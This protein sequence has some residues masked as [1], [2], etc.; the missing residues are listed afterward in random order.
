MRAGIGRKYRG[1]CEKSS[2]PASHRLAEARNESTLLNN[3]IVI[4]GVLKISPRFPPSTGGGK[5]LPRA[6]RGTRFGAA[7]PDFDVGRRA[8]DWPGDMDPSQSVWLIHGGQGRLVGGG[9]QRATD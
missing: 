3:T 1:R 7:V 2:A 9:S 8:G 5:K 4:S 6:T